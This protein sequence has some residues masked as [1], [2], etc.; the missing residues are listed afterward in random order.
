VREQNHA[1]DT[2]DNGVERPQRL[3]KIDAIQIK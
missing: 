3:L 1:L 2:E